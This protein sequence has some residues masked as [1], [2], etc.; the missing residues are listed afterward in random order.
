MKEYAAIELF[1]KEYYA[2]LCATA[3]KFVSS[4]E[5][6]Q[7]I[8]QEVIIRFWEKQEQ[9]QNLHS[10]ENYLFTMV[11]NESFNYLRSVRREN[12]RHQKLETPETEEPQIFNWLVEEETNQLLMTAINSLPAQS[13][14]ILR[15]TLS[16]YENKEI[17]RLLEISINT[18]K[19][20][21]YGAI[22]KLRE[23]FRQMPP[24]HP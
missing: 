19:T 6:A 2:A 16:G 21:K 3:L 18:V 12:Q 5:I 13:A 14:R 10:V 20:L 15:L 11:R 8:A 7:D 17:A 1:V 24:E 9:Q 22:R 23:Y 4:P